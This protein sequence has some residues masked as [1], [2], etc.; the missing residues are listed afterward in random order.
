[1]SR[2][3]LGCDPIS[4]DVEDFFLPTWSK[5]N[6]TKNFFCSLLANLRHRTPK[7]ALPSFASLERKTK[8]KK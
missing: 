3:Q 1:M 7:P 8:H 6:N 5:T 2:E 4:R